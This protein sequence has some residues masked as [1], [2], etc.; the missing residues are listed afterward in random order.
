M[1]LSES[2]LMQAALKPFVQERRRAVLQE[3]LEIMARY[4]I[5]SLEELRQMLTNGYIPEH[6]GWEDFVILENLEARLEELDAY[7]EDI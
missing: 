3:R 2:E 4:E 1:S 5:N 7:L 6:P